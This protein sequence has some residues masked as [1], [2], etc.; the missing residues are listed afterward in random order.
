VS[1][2]RGESS[3]T[4]PASNILRAALEVLFVASYT[5]R[6]WMTSEDVSR[7][8]IHD[9]WEALHEIPSLLTRWRPDAEAELLTYLDEYAAKWS[10]PNL[11]ARYLQVRDG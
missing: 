1:K 4:L 11:R 9:L 10:E 7:R 5:T 6:N 3:L 2:A 8:Q